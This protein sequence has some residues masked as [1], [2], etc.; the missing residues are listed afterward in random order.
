MVVLVRIATCCLF[1]GVGW[2]NTLLPDPPCLVAWARPATHLNTAQG[3]LVQCIMPPEAPH[4]AVGWH[5]VGMI[6]H[7]MRGRGMQNC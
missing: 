4:P 3:M 5:A 6:L 7:G 1:F 2:V